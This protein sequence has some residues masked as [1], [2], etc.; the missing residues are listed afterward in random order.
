MKKHLFLLAF[1]IS[2]LI[3]AATAL[4]ADL[5]PPPPPVEQLRPASYD[6]TGLYIGGWIGAACIDGTLTDNTG[7][8]ANYLNAGCGGKGGIL[9]GYNY[10]VNDFVM[11]VEA[12]WGRSG[13]IVENNDPAADF[14]FTLD[15]IATLRARFGVAFDDTLLFVT[16]GG[17]WATGDLDGIISGTPNNITANHYGWTIGAGIEHA[18]T[19]N[20]RVKMDYLYTKLNDA[21]YTDGGGCCD[22]DVHWGDEHEVRVGAIFAF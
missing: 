16:G 4:A 3:P 22:V 5:D 21:N 7:G 12:D 19:E 20:F 8:G 11:G 9:G 10:Q 6:W 15:N 17:A 2:A 14:S 13:S 1:A 18:V